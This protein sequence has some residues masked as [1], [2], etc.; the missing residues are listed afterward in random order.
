MVEIK[1]ARNGYVILTIKDRKGNVILHETVRPDD[2]EIII[3]RNLK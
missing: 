2:V 3:A 1:Q